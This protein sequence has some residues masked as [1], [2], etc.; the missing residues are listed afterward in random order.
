MKATWPHGFHNQTKSKA[1]STYL[2]EKYKLLNWKFIRLE[3]RD[4]KDD[5]VPYH[6][7]VDE[8]SLGKKTWNQMYKMIIEYLEK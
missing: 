4:V 6:L 7:I 8:K 1:T 2:D 3:K 5:S